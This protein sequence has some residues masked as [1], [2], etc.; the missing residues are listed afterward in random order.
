VL[1]CEEFAAKVSDYIEG[2]VEGSE[3]F[4]MWLHAAICGHCRRYMKQLDVVIDLTSSLDESE[5]RAAR[6]RDADC[7]EK[8]SDE[9]RDKLLEA[10]REKHQHTDS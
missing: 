7:P 3:K 1:T 5:Q 9:T 6:S 4:S 2:H 8:L 10:F